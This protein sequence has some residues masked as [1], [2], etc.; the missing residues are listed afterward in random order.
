MKIF[1]FFSEFLEFF[2]CF[3]IDVLL[4]IVVAVVYNSS[5]SSKFTNF[6]QWFA[7]HISRVVAKNLYFKND[8]KFKASSHCLSLCIIF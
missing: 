8:S 3:L 5:R 4:Y 7:F 6:G 2:D 1:D